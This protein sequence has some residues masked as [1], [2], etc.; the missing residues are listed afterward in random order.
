[1]NQQ[2]DQT[3]SVLCFSSLDPTGGS[4]IQADIETLASIGCHCC[5]VLTVL[6]AQDTVDEKDHEPIPN[7]LIVEQARAVLEDMPIKA[8]KIG[9]MGSVETVEAIHT[10]LTDYPELPVVLDP[11]FQALQ[12]DEPIRQHI[13]Q[14]VNTLLLPL[15]SIATP[16][17]EEARLLASD[18]DTLEACVNSIMESGCEYVLVTGTQEKSPQVTHRMW[19]KRQ[20]VIQLSCQRLPYQ[21]HGSGCTLSSAIAGYLA[22]GTDMATAVRNAQTFTWQTLKHAQ[23]LGMGQLIPQRLFWVD[24]QGRPIGDGSN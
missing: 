12:T 4:G 17:M 9:P 14:A 5:P 7:T 3:P 10:L 23:R 18:A 15:A 6:T 20:E 22:H 19:G 24:N 1:M 11:G 8:V 2:S 21:Y 16:N 13:I